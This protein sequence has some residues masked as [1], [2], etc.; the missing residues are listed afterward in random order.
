MAMYCEGLSE[1]I[2]WLRG[3]DRDELIDY[4][5]GLYGT[6]HL[7]DDASLDDLLN[8][9]IRQCKE[10]HKIVSDPGWSQ[11]DFYTKVLQVHREDRL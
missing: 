10:D 2:N 6:D 9:A 7:S 5:S 1:M 11:V 8:E 4:M 3:R